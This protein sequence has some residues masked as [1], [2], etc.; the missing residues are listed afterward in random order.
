MSP[1]TNLSEDLSLVARSSL[2][3]MLEGLVRTRNFTPEHA[4][5][6]TGVACD[7]RIGNVVD[8]PNYAVSTI[9]P[10]EIFRKK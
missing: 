6:I 3:N 2:I 7:M 4:Y 9:C 8:V 10:L 5:V 1:L